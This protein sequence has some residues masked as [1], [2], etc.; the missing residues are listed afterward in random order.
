[1]ETLYGMNHKFI[2]GEE[3]ENP[4]EIQKVSSFPTDQHLS[5]NLLIVPEQRI[6]GYR[7]PQALH[8]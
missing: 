4:D 5:H 6:A 3:V 2:T 8:Q 1:M 7:E